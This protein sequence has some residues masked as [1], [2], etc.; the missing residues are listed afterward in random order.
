M[1]DKIKL[2]FF[3]TEFWQAGTQRFTFELDQAIDK[4]VFEISILSFRRL[5]TLPEKKDFFIQSIKI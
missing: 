5:N 2:L 3:V 1:A 4:E